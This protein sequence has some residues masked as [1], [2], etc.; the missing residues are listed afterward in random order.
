M[1]IFFWSIIDGFVKNMEVDIFDK[2][3]KEVIFNMKAI[4]LGKE[5]AFFL[6]TRQY[7]FIRK[8]EK[9]TADFSN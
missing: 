4:I 2:N 5:K 8:S 1:V 6:R 9:N 7:F 3:K